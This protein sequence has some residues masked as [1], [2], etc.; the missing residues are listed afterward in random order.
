[1]NVEVIPKSKK[2]FG[3]LIIDDPLVK[4]KYGCLDY[5]VLLQLMKDHNFFTEVAFIPWNYQRNRRKAVD[6]F[7]E[8]NK[9]YQLCVHGCNHTKNEF[10]TT[11]YKKLKELASLSMWRMQRMQE[12]TGLGFDPIM[13]FPQGKFSTVAMKALKDTGYFA[14][15]NSGIISTDGIEPQINEY[16]KTHTLIFDDFPLYLRHY[17]EREAFEKDIEAGRPLVI[18]AHHNDFADGYNKFTGF[19]DWLNKSAAIEWVSLLTISEYYQQKSYVPIVQSQVISTDSFKEKC[20]II[21]RRYLSEFRDNYV[22]KSRFLTCIKQ[23][24]KH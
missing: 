15:F 2:I 13:V 14:A 22:H 11:D 6:F 17:P 8:N 20:K 24:F 16:K 18:V 1:M 3:C 7:K 10:G 4:M 12:K 21:T 23:T 5:Q 19:I 9:Y